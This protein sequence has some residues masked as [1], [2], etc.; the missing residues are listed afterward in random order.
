MSSIDPM[1]TAIDWLD[2]YRAA[3]PSIVDLYTPDA[4]LECVCDGSNTLIGRAA[5]KEYWRLRFREKPAGQLVGLHFEGTFVAISYDTEGDVVQAVLQI[6]DEG[7]I[8]RSRCAPLQSICPIA[9]S[10]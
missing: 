10:D 6:N 5:I 8:V 7:K 4:A 1:A 2:S 3:D 9:P